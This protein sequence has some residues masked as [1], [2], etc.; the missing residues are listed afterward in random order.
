MIP[1]THTALAIAHTVHRA[2]AKR[3]AQEKGEWEGY[4]EQ[5][6]ALVDEIEQAA[7][8]I[9]ESNAPCEE[10]GRPPP[11]ERPS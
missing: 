3:Y 5:C 1:G 2:N 4:A 10:G 11:P 6:S 9:E 8:T 7:K